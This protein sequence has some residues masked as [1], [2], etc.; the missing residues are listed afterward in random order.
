[1]QQVFASKEITEDEQWHKL[2]RKEVQN[3][4]NHPADGEAWKDFDRNYRWFAADAR[5]IRLGLATDSFNTF[6]QMSSSYSMWPVFLIPYNFPIWVCIEQSNFMMSLLIPGR[7]CPGKN[8]DVFLEPLIEELQDFWKGVLTFDAFSGKKFDLHSTVIWCIHDYPGLG[9][10]S[11]RV[12]RG[13][14]ACVHCDKKPCSRKIRNK[15]CYIGHHRFL[16]R[17]YTWRKKKD[18]DGQIE[19]L[20][21]LE[22]ISTD[23]L[24]QQLERVSDV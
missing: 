16:A 4:L 1:L 6:G 11:G 18:F 15:I 23:E 2:K 5:K 3:E 10:L 19:K 12:T 7:Q 24:M 21:A 13:Y 20:D 17:D 22:E 14:Y 8:F 9:T